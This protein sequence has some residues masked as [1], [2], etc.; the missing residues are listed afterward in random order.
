MSQV[1]FLIDESLPLS[2]VAGL[3]RREPAIE[4]RRVGQDLIP[5]FGTPDPEILRFCE[6]NE[7]LFVSLDRASIPDHV[8]A[9]LASGHH[10]SGV[11]LVTRQCTLR[12]IIDDLVIIWAAS[13]RDEWKD[14]L[15]YLPL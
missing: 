10:T 5:S 1:Q 11:L 15:M 13:E 8:S 3:R 7:R 9:H 2:L 6:Q 14:V 4:V 12:S